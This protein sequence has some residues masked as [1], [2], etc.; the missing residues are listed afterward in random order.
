M[1]AYPFHSMFFFI[2]FISLHSEKDNIN[3]IVYLV[4]RINSFLRELYFKKFRNINS[5][6]NITWE[7]QPLLLTCCIIEPR[8]ILELNGVLNNMAQ[9]YGNTD[10]GL[11]IFHGTKNIDLVKKNIKTWKNVKLI[12]LGIENL[13]LL[14]YSQFRT[15]IHFYKNI[16]SKY[17]LI[18]EWDSY[19][20]RKIPLHY[21]VYDYVGARWKTNHGNQCGNGGFSLRNVKSMIETIQKNKYNNEPE[22]LY[23]A[24]NHHLKICSDKNKD[25]FSSEAYV[26]L[27]CVGCHKPFCSIGNYKPLINLIK[28]YCLANIFFNRQIVYFFM[29][30]ILFKLFKYIKLLLLY[31][32]IK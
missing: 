13:S 28:I 23:F 18:F 7:K 32:K 25:L 26:N 22:D 30:N 6:L 12:N 14:E 1:F 10:V 19:I 4:K 29:I 16:H 24:K 11:T 27:N 21:F 5:V 20:F 2:L 9:I 3:I 17:I 15:S 8:N 31:N